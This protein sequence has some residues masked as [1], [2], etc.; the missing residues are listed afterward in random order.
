MFM[1][2][3]KRMMQIKPALFC[4]AGKHGRNRKKSRHCKTNDSGFMQKFFFQYKTCHFQ[5]Q[6]TYH[7]C[8]GKMHQLRMQR[9]QPGHLSLFLGF[10]NF[11]L[12]Y[13]R[14][15][16]RVFRKQLTAHLAAQIINLAVIFI[17]NYLSTLVSHFLPADRTN[18]ITHFNQL[19]R[20]RLCY[21]GCGRNSFVLCTRGPCDT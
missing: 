6:S 8:Y 3:Q 18:L 11:I 13:F 21:G 17:L 7:K 5:H 4:F 2:F 16:G 20:F 15:F 19:C 10:G 14:I 1:D 12:G 9:Y